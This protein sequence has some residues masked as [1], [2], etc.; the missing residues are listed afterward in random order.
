MPIVVD[1][2]V[3]LAKRKMSADRPAGDVAALAATGRLR[4]RPRGA[5]S[6][7]ASSWAE[8]NHEGSELSGESDHPRGHADFVPGGVPV[9][10]QGRPNDDRHPGREGQRLHPGR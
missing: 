8:P 7:S 10:G 9:G 4:L 6:G 3:M 2:D 5:S 1:I